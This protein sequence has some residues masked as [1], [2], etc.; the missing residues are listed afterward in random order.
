[1]KLVFRRPP[2]SRRRVRQEDN[3]APAVRALY[4]R[5]DEDRARVDAVQRTVAGAR[6]RIVETR[7]RLQAAVVP[8]PHRN[9]LPLPEPRRDRSRLPELTAQLDVVHQ[10]LLALSSRVELEMDR[11]DI[12]RRA[13]EEA[14]AAG[15]D[16]S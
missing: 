7:S 11:L 10:R 15:G 9:A 5:I 6:R 4:E 12:L 14:A 3:P 1:M 8:T 13:I 16:P 2:P